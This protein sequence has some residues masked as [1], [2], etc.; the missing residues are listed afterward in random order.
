MDTALCIVHIERARHGLV[1]EVFPDWRVT[2]S[3]PPDLPVQIMT[4]DRENMVPVQTAV[5]LDTLVDAMFKEV[6]KRAADGAP[7]G[8]TAA[9]DDFDQVLAGANEFALDR[10]LRHAG[11]LARCVEVD[12][13]EPA[14]RSADWA[15]D[16]VTER[17]EATGSWPAA[18]AA[19]CAELALAETVE[20]PSPTDPD[21]MSWR[22]P[23]PGGHVRHFLARRAIE[24]LLQERDK[25]VR[26]EPAELKRPW[27]YG[28]FVRACEEALPEG[29]LPEAD[30]DA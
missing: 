28:F 29:T 13:F 14:R 19:V 5:V 2:I 3:G 23:G 22:V 18:L 12:F 21:A 30:S 24:E 11:Y 7:K 25:P 8:A 6:E 20:R 26:G 9:L 1:A 27:L 15:E 17:Y 10:A 16:A 4:D